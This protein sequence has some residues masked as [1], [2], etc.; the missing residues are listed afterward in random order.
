MKIFVRKKIDLEY[1]V[2][3]RNIIAYKTSNSYYIFNFFI[4]VKFQQILKVRPNK[5]KIISKDNN[6]LYFSK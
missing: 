4:S 2:F 5:N 1:L 3:Y 6:E